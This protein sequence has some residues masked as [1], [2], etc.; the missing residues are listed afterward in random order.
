MCA[1]EEIGKLTVAVTLAAA[2]N[3]P[4]SP[5]CPLTSRSSRFRV[6]A[7]YSP[8]TVLACL[9][10]TIAGKL[11][12]GAP[13]SW[14]AAFTPLWLGVALHVLSRALIFFWRDTHRQTVNVRAAS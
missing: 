14:C 12:T 5:V 9:P 1:C 4:L 11:E 7:A 13:A 2:H 10:L 3:P 6:A 8:F